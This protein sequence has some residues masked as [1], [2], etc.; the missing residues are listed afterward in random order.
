M[1]ASLTSGGGGRGGGD[2]R[3][4]PRT[5]HGGQWLIVDPQS[6]FAAPPGRIAWSTVATGGASRASYPP[7]S[8]LVP[9]WVVLH[10]PSSVPAVVAEFICE[11]YWVSDG[12]QRVSGGGE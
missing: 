4:S 11:F 8:G 3:G 5:V 9:Q 10:H 2:G 7:Q 6:R 1:D 12:E